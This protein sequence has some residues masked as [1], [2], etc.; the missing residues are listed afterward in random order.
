MSVKSIDYI[1]SGKNGTGNAA[2]LLPGGAIEALEAR[3]GSLTINIKK[4]K[5]FVKSALRNG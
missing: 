5:G 4:R 3:P 1:L 2:V